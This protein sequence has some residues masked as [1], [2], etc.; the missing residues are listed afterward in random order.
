MVS[1]V[2]INEGWLVSYFTRNNEK[3]SEKFSVIEP[4][5]DFMLSLGVNDDA[6]DDAII[7]LHTEANIRRVTFGKDGRVHNTDVI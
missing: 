4:A 1:L 2:K 3:L 7:I 6:I 5:A